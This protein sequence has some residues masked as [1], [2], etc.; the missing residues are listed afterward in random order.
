[1]KYIL[2]ISL[3]VALPGIIGCQRSPDVNSHPCR[4]K[5]GICK[6]SNPCTEDSCDPT[7]NQCRFKP[8]ESF[9][10]LPRI[11]IETPERAASFTEAGQVLVQGYAKSGIAD[12]KEFSLNGDV[13]PLSPEGRFSLSVTPEF[14]MNLVVST[15]K[16]EAGFSA[17]AARSFFYSTDWIPRDPHDA[18]VSVI[19]DALMVWMGRE[20]VDDGIHNWDHVDDLATVTELLIAHQPIDDDDI[21]DEPISVMEPPGL[22]TFSVYVTEVRLGKPGVDLYL[23]AGG[24]HMT[25]TY[26]FIEVDIEIRQPGPTVGSQNIY[27]A[28][29]RATPLF[30]DVDVGI[31]TAPGGG[32][33][34]SVSNIDVELKLFDIALDLENDS[35]ESSINAV[36][37]TGGIKQIFVSQI[38]TSVEEQLSG[39]LEEVASEAINATAFDFETTFPPLLGSEDSTPVTLHSTPQS[40]AF[41]PVRGTLGLS[42]SALSKRSVYY[43]TKGSISRAGCALRSLEPLELSPT[44]P[45]QVAVSDDF[46][47]QMLF[48]VWWGGGLQFPVPRNEEAIAQ[49]ARLG[50]TDLQIAVDMLHPPVLTSCNDHDELRMQVGDMKLRVLLEISGTETVGL[51]V[52]TSLETS[53]NYKVAP[54]ESGPL[55]TLD[56][57]DILQLETEVVLDDPGISRHL[58]AL[59]EFIDEF[60]IVSLIQSL[61]QDAVAGFPLPALDL[62][63]VESIPPG[64]ELSVDPATILRTKGFTVLQGTF[65]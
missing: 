34:V 51:D 47:N 10:C 56:V 13:I 60:F 44:H 16:D 15:L 22:G 17:K 11:V 7:S 53:V 37:D 41:N 43:P 36:L 42:A 54:G 38:E 9:E 58:E 28:L 12:I 25:V 6:D 33:E 23:Q 8:I 24:L 40:A 55:I 63:T 50:I 61:T 19:D 48:S 46:I 14:G 27:P 31:A 1:M 5:D 29:A 18:K 26:A 30:I 4:V 3:V 21:G 20:A 35:L 2:I 49:L 32:V 65:R 39:R 62:S 52:Y 57:I 45:T 59:R 64:Y